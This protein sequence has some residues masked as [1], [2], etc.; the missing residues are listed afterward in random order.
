MF[1]PVRCFI[2]LHKE[3]ELFNFGYCEFFNIPCIQG[4]R[5]KTPSAAPP[6]T[7]STDIY[8]DWVMIEVDTVKVRKVWQLVLSYECQSCSAC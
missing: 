5:V 1:G 8:D 6:N 4:K 2:F 3:I 7:S